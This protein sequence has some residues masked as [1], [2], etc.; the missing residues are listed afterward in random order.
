MI[1]P[2]QD[3]NILY[4]GGSGGFVFFHWMM[5]M[6][7]H[8]CSLPLIDPVAKKFRHR[9]YLTM[10][11]DIETYH[12]IKDSSWPKYDTYCANFHDLPEH[13]KKE[14]ASQYLHFGDDTVNIPEW[15]EENIT[16]IVCRQWQIGHW[17]KSTECWPDNAIT[18][19]TKCHGRSWKI[20]FTCNNT[21]QW[22]DL[23]GTKILLYTDLQTQIRLSGYKKAW[24]FIPSLELS[25]FATTKH[26]LKSRSAMFGDDLVFDAVLAASK[27]SHYSIKLQKFIRD[28]ADFFLYNLNQAQKKLLRQWISL[29]SRS[30][31]DKTA[32]PHDLHFDLDK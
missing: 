5:L 24:Y 8:Y 31:L 20:Y 11:L 14:S 21:S 27:H 18:K 10:P 29:H 6:G 4:F 1:D 17:W 23:P 16:E 26:L 19:N 32:L 2:K 9:F 15:Y 25:Y 22:L 30:L 13:I 28:L 12:K 3:I 7:L